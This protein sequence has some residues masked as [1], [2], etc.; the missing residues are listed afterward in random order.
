MKKWKKIVGKIV[1]L[2]RYVVG[3][4]SYELREPE[5][6][7][8]VLGHSNTLLCQLA[9]IMVSFLKSLIRIKPCV[10]ASANKREGQGFDEWE[11]KNLL[12][13]RY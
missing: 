13:R 12:L 3:Y 2:W 7:I 8:S 5:L 10:F 11:E 9:C 4:V 6:L 1:L